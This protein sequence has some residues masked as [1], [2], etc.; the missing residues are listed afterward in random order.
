MSKCS[1]REQPAWLKLYTDTRTMVM[2]SPSECL[3][4][5]VKGLFRLLTEPEYQ[6]EDLSV[7][8]LL[9]FSQLRKGTDESV[10]DYYS[11]VA[12]GKKGSAVRWGHAPASL[13]EMPCEIPICDDLSPAMKDTLSRINEMNRK[14]AEEA[15]E[16]YEAY[17]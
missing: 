10:A 15:V 3:G 17:D 16:A 5:A 11:A 8:A 13:M 4:D 1:R 9:L 14:M 6:G 2:A 7:P 12:N